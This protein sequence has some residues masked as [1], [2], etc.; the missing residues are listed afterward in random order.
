MISYDVTYHQ[1]ILDDEDL[2]R[3]PIT[4]GLKKVLHEN[5]CKKEYLQ[6]LYFLDSKNFD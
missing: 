5:I 3:Q 6:F 1:K 2:L 4:V